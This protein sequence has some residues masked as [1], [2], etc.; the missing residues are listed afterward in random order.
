MGFQDVIN[1]STFG[2][3]VTTLQNQGTITSFQP[4]LAPAGYADQFATVDVLNATSFVS[5]CPYGSTAGEYGV[6]AY[7]PTSS[8]ARLLAN[9]GNSVRVW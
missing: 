8:S 4:V 7:G 3:A 2:V 5:L 6:C 9:L 1:E